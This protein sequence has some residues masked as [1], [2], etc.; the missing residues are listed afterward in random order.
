LRLVPE[1]NARVEIGRMRLLLGMV[2]GFLI[3]VAGAYFHDAG[4]RDDRERLV[5]WDVADQTFRVAKDNAQRG[6]DR[7]TGRQDFAPDDQRERL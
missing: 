5:N 6:W 2:F 1:I 4:I 7:L 3:T